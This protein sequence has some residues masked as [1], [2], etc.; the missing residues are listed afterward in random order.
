MGGSRRL[1]VGTLFSWT[2]SGAIITCQ[3]AT[4][5]VIASWTRM[6]KWANPFMALIHWLTKS[7]LACVPIHLW[8]HRLFTFPTLQCQKWANSFAIPLRER[9]L[10]I[11][12]ICTLDLE[13]KRK[14]N[15]LSL[16]FKCIICG[17]YSL[18]ECLLLIMQLQSVLM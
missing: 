11:F 7:P 16:N 2:L 1:G 12:Y 17:R 5:I 10:V 8:A 6:G 13:A 15:V 14:M 3:I 4:G 9:G 18:G